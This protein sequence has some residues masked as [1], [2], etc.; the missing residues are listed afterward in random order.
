MARFNKDT[1]I[2]CLP[3]SVYNDLVNALNKDS[4]WMTLATH[5]AEWLEYPG[6][7]W[8]QSL[9][10]IKHPHESSGQK[11]LSEL[12]IKMCTVEILC[13]LLNECNLLNVLS[14]LSHSEPL[15]IIVHPTE[16]LQTN[17]LKISFGQHLRLC[18]MAVGMPPPNYIWYH[19]DAQLQ[20]CTSNQL[21]IIITSASQSGEYRC[22]V[23]QIKHDGTL[24]STLISKAVTVQVCPIP[25]KIE[26][27][28]QA[29]IE[30][31]AG[32]SYTISCEA[33]GYPKPHY[34]WFH[35]NTKLEGETS[36]T[37]H[38]QKFSSK[39]EGKYYCYIYNDISEVYTEK[40]H[41]M[42]DY[43]RLK[44]VA[45]IALI[46][47]NGEYEHHGTLPT[48]RN[49]A[50]HIAN[51][52]KEIDFEVICLMNLTITQMKKAIQ[53]FSEALVAGV[54]GLFYFAGHGFKI[55]E[56]YMLA[57]DSPETYLRKD[58]ICESELLT[59]FLKNDPKL[60]IIILDMCQTL[61]PKEFN[62]DIYR[63]L[64][65]V[66]EY[67]SNK[68]L[69]NLIQAYSTSSYRP[70]YEKVNSKYGLYVTHL[71]KYITENITVTKIFENVGKSFDSSFKGKER[72]QIPM[73]ASSVTKPF[74]LTDAIYKKNLP[75]SISYLNKIIS[76]STQTLNIT[77]KQVNM[78][79]RI[80]ISLFM[81]PYLNSIKIKV[82][83]LQ[84]VEINFLNYIP[85]K[86]NN[87]YQDQDRK[88]CWIH[89]PQI[90]EGPLIISI[91]KNGTPI[92]AT[93][94][95]IKD[96][97]PPLLKIINC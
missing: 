21:D 16:E 41:V 44:A 86:R 67:K 75:D 57:T 34:Q 65:T 3:I 77:F 71:S 49:D 94:L 43:P 88:E 72:N 48:A 91:A 52:L 31:K 11:L 33:N 28:P 92:D 42:M 25:V 78:S 20:N 51:L 4:A 12:N 38:I 81:E 66:N 22:K 7:L 1:F 83:D 15:N 10:D 26:K 23:L 73:F 47:A 61:P 46:I 97:I 14:I 27:Q 70:S 93:L 56:S 29:L 64:P 53:L 30:V 13:T 50:A 36:N 63:E 18:C 89:N 35:E 60:L 79:T 19:G 58:A 9:K 37:L 40:T 45:K 85:A 95:H 59:A 24:I 62:P 8:I 84:N 2:E 87:L 74:R 39:Y 54:Y 90:N 76:F 5:V 80:I 17:I 68:N 32:D 6:A 55:Q 82:L 69:R 96:Y